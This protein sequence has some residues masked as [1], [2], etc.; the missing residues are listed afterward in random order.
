MMVTRVTMMVGLHSGGGDDVRRVCDLRTRSVRDATVARPCS[1]V[2]LELHR[3]FFFTHPWPSPSCVVWLVYPLG[4][5]RVRFQWLSLAT[6]RLRSFLGPGGQLHV[7]YGCEG[8]NTRRG[9]LAVERWDP[10]SLSFAY[11]RYRQRV[12]YRIM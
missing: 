12:R 6:S 1:A 3:R 11:G 2:F 9:Q 7:N 4:P 10:C 5:A 8:A